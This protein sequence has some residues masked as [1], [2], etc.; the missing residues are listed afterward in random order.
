[1][2]PIALHLHEMGLQLEG[3]GM[4]E[5]VAALGVAEREIE[6]LQEQLDKKAAQPWT[7]TEPH[8]FTQG[9]IAWQWRQSCRCAAC[10]AETRKMQR[11]QGS[12]PGPADQA[13]ESR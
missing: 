5:I 9:E 10:M 1:M 3:C 6:R 13:E 11:Y 12:M 2:N 7:S 8:H 4:P